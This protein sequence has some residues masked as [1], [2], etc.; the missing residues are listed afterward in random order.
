MRSASF[1]LLLL[2]L[3]PLSGLAHGDLHLQIEEATRRIAQAPTNAELY[4]RRGELHRAHQDWDAAQAD[5]DRTLS[6]NPKLAIVDLARGKMFLEA[7]WPLSAI[8]ALDRFLAGHTNHIDALITRAR[9]LVKLG[10]RLEAAGDYDQAIACAARPQP[11]IFLE[12]SQALTTEGSAYF[13]QALSGLDAGM[14]KLGPLV[15]LQL[16]AIDLELKQKHFDGA[17]ARLERVAA[18]N[19]RKETWLARR[20]E[21]LQE[22]G[23]L[24]EA[25]DAYRAA[26]KAMAELPPS[27]RQVPAMV[28]LEKRIRHAL[29]STLG[30]GQG[31]GLQ[32]PK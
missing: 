32:D 30:A 29:Q 2:V 26:L 27:R 10:K 15:T 4:L 22:A 8:V 14:Q 7:N 20:G 19:P 21:I 31:K 13:G 16:F 23:R 1:C 12:R 9:A 5:Y 25:S 11:E 24:K 18:Q 3:A 17:L 6:L 28:E